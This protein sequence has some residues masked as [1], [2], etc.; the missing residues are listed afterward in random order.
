MAKVK[1]SL[2]VVTI[3]DEVTDGKK[4]YISIAY[5]YTALQGL[6]LYAGAGA[7]DETRAECI[8]LLAEL[9]S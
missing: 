1:K 3:H 4:R 2:P 9:D 6:Q 5:V 8:R 7:L